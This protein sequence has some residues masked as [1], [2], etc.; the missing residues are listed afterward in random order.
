MNKTNYQLKISDIL[1]LVGMALLAVYLFIAG[2]MNL[3]DVTV[4]SKGYEKTEGY[5]T[6][7]IE[8][9]DRDHPNSYDYK[10]VVEF[11]ADGKK[12]TVTAPSDRGYKE[13]EGKKHIVKYDPSNPEKAYIGDGVP[14][15]AFDFFSA[16]FLIAVI[17]VFWLPF[18]LSG[19]SEKIIME[20]L[21]LLIT[22]GIGA[23]ALGWSKLAAGTINPFN[24][25]V[26]FLG[27][28]FLGAAALVIIGIT[29]EK[30]NVG[31]NRDGTVRRRGSR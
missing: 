13:E 11:E 6:E 24:N 23:A 31:E 29:S 12:Y 14:G 25:Y 10:F 30:K 28:A 9:Y 22:A 5:V 17:F 27:Y 1:I 2:C 16:A 21:I 7:L 18:L 19:R 15:W 8:L 4:K 26:C 3:I 20:R